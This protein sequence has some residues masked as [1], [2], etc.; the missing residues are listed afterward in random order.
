MTKAEAGI[1]LLYGILAFSKPEAF[2]RIEDFKK[3]DTR[4]VLKKKLL[5]YFVLLHRIMTHMY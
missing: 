1:R 5:G 2:K 4:E 3:R